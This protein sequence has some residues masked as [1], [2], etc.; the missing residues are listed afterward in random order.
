MASSALK[1]AGDAGARAASDVEGDEEAIDRT[2]SI[3]ALDGDGYDA[4]DEAEADADADADAEVSEPQPRGEVLTEEPLGPDQLE[5]LSSL[6]GESEIGIETA[7]VREGRRSEVAQSEDFG[8][9]HSNDPVRVYLREMGQVSLLTREGEVEIAQRIEAGEHRQHYATIGTSFGIREVLRMADRLR[10]GK[11]EPKWILDGIE[12]ETDEEMGGEAAAQAAAESLERQRQT[13][14]AA[15]AKVRRSEAEAARRASALANP[16]TGPEARERLRAELAERYQ[17]MVD[18]LLEARF[19]K[20]RLGEIVGSLEALSRAFAELRARARVLTQSFQLSPE[21]FEELALLA[22]RKSRRG[23]D[24]LARL[25]GDPQLVEQ[26][27]SELARVQA[28]AGEL[29]AEHRMSV[30]EVRTALIRFDRARS[31][32]HGAKCELIEAN[33]RLVVSIAK[34]YTNRGLQFLDLIQEG[35]IGLM[36]AVDKFEYKRGYKFSTYATW[37]IRQA[38]TRAIADQARTIRIPVH[39]GQRERKIACRIQKVA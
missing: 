21:E 32:T 36:K 35:N 4:L 3:E 10:K 16:R 34:K 38:I 5:E 39:I 20:A 23:R 28:E 29:E 17:A 26:L 33:L 2:E 22:T 30:E 1:N 37:W 27:R 11:C 18:L 9:A 8:E 31:E 25:G 14:V 19:S 7:R 24:A 15:L 12:D 6:F 13:L